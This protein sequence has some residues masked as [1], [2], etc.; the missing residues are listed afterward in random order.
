DGAVFASYGET[1]LLATAQ[2]APGRPDIDFFPLTV[3]Y[4]EKTYAAGKVPG[5]FF[6]REMRPRDHEVLIARSIDRP[7]R[8][9]FPDGYRDE[10]QLI[11]TVC[12][13]DRE[14][15]PDNLAGVA[16][17][18]ALTLSSIP[19]Q[20]PGAAVRVGRVDE[21][22][23][24]NP[25]TAQ[26]AVSTLDL[27]IAGTADAVT[28]VEAG[29]MELPESVMADAILFG[30]QA[31]VGICG[32]I[33]ELVA[34][35]GKPKQAVTPPAPNP[36][37]AQVQAHRAAL[38]A[39][40]ATPGK[41]AKSKAVKTLVSEK[42]KAL[43]GSLPDAERIVAE[44]Q[45]KSAFHDL[46]GENERRNIA[47]RGARADGR[48]LKDIRPIN[49]ELGVLARTHGSSLFTRGETQA[50]VTITLGTG[51]DEQIIDGL[52]D[53]YSKRF[54]LHYNFPPYSVGEVRRLVGTSRREI[55][56][57]NLAE[58]AVNAVMPPPEEFPYSAR[59]VSEILESNGS[60]SMATVCGA[61]L[62]LFDAGCPLR[63]PVAGIAMG[64]I[65]EGDEFFVL[66]DILGSEDHNGDMD[67][68]VA[69]TA[70]GVTALQMDIKVKGLSGALLHRALEQAREGRMHILG[71]MAEAIDAARPGVSKWAPVL[72]LKQ[73]PVEKIGFLIGPGG[74][75][76]KGLQ[77]QFNV[78]IEVND[79][80]AVTVAGGPGS[81]LPAAVAQIEAICGDAEL[82]AVYKGK[83]VS[84]REFG[85][86]VEIFP[87]KEG[88]LH[89]SEMSKGGG[90]VKK[91]DDVMKIGDV[92]E[93]KV[94]NI[95]DI[96][97]VR[98]SM[99]LEAPLGGPG[100]GGGGER[101]GRPPMAER[102]MP[103]VGEVYEGEVTGLKPYGA[104]IE[105][106]PG[107]EG[108]CHVSEMGTGYV[109][110]PA[111]VVSVGDKVKV[112]VLDVEESG[113]IRLSIKQADPNFKDQP[114]ATGGRDGG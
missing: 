80:G 55:G 83:V 6:K 24:L 93:V 43:A 25:T 30:H 12:S 68:K 106:L 5:G 75:T 10:V 15:E 56:H 59:V 37:T 78:R 103:N 101:G 72:V 113:R 84:I 90:F 82:G 58:R 31:I 112:K 36:W 4:R 13:Y 60:S 99:N 64:L 61:S 22:F 77:T 20:G 62:A 49:I 107:T 88:L 87:G 102:Q 65:K 26:M 70:N 111:D 108:L 104:F 47:E 109:K 67:F 94:V 71:R 14:S 57:G 41:H 1:S 17:M 35:A 40:L 38:A 34:Q 11:V 16:A 63:S 81:D 32:M 45:L 51:R 89:V 92:V 44:K 98:L 29:A 95:D 21:Q 76:I 66:S 46:E 9:L 42:I 27:V 74:K 96:G 105:V 69:G 50:L 86:F 19:F 2:S 33:A 97:R 52:Q 114:V 54:M 7:V 100:G 39:A 79:D 85:A 73:I 110:D 8:P 18:A 23:V 28:M 3:E 91:I 53:E 48:G